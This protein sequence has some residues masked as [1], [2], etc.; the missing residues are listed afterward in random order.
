ME[1]QQKIMGYS[2]IILLVIIL[3]LLLVITEQLDTINHAVGGEDKVFG[4]DM[5]WMEKGEKTDEHSEREE[6]E[7]AESKEIT[8]TAE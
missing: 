1:K 3:G 5:S 6:R 8:E 2:T 7:G 4:I